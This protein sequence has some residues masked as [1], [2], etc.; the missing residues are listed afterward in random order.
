M[1]VDDIALTMHPEIGSRTAIHLVEC[2][3]SAERLF[4]A[5]QQEIV[6]RSGLKPELARSISR[7][8]YH[9]R[10]SGSSLS[11]RGTGSGRSTRARRTIPAGSRS[12]PTIRT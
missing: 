10:R 4:A 2:F 8:E 3:G 6:L 7:R 11:S 12:A 9:G 1:T 5:T